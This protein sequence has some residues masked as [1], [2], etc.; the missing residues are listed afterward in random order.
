MFCSA[1]VGFIH[2]RSTKPVTPGVMDRSKLERW[3]DAGL[4]LYQFHYYDSMEA[5]LPLDYPASSLGLDKPV[6]VGEAQ[7][8]NVAGKMDTIYENSYRGVL[9]W[10][11]NGDDGYDFRAVADDYMNWEK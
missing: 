6:F 9:F 2:E 5:T 4:D 1:F 8:S 7:P 10:S 3:T 11:L